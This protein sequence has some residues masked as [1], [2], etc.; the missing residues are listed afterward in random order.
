MISRSFR[1]AT[2]RANGRKPKYT[3]L[4][5][6]YRDARS[7][8]HGR[9]TKC[10]WVYPPGWPECWSTFEKFRTWALANGFSKTNNSPDRQRPEEPYGPNNVVWTTGVDNFG[11]SRGS[12]YYSALSDLATRGREPPPMEAGSI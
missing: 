1:T 6:R 9:A 7:R 10:P 11:R 8:A 4:Y 2:S 5:I 3:L 12:R